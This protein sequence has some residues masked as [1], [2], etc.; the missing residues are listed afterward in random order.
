MKKIEIVI[1]TGN[2]NKLKEYKELFNN[3]PVVVSSLTDEGIDLEVE[4][5]GTTFEENSLIK[6]RYVAEKLNKIIIAD[7]SGL[8]VHAL[9]DFPGIYSARFMKEHTYLERNLKI[10]EM[11]LEH[12]D[13][14]AHF[15]CAIVF[16]DKKNNIEKV[17]TGQCEGTIVPPRE[18]PNGFGYDPIFL[19][20]D[21][22]DTFS[23]LSEEEKNE[24]S[25]RGIASKKLI[26]YLNEYLKES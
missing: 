26:E 14:S 1:A 2:K 23:V 21:K 12:E 13:K 22:K 20:M 8:C 25:H 24:I 18:G 3:L 16:V 4:E 10:N 9:N 6:A 7:D 11:L 5:N 17:F 15:T 19:P